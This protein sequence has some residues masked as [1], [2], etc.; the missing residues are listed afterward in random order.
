MER[1]VAATRNQDMEMHRRLEEKEIELSESRVR[2][3]QLEELQERQSTGAPASPT[4]SKW[5]AVVRKAL[6]HDTVERVHKLSAVSSALEARLQDLERLEALEEELAKTKEAAEKHKQEAAEKER[7]LAEKLQEEKSA[8]EKAKDNEQKAKE[9]A[10]AEREAAQKAEDKAQK[11]RER[12]DKEVAEAKER[13]E[14]AK[15]EATEAKERAEAQERAAQEARDSVEK[16][17]QEAAEAKE[18][19]EAKDREAREARDALEGAKQEAAEAK[20]RAE[21][22]D[23]EAQEAR[24]A[25]D[26]ARQ[27]AAGAKARGLQDAPEGANTGSASLALEQAQRE[28]ADAQRE[29]ASAQKQVAE[30]QRDA[31]E[32]QA[33]AA[34]ALSAAAQAVLSAVQEL[35]SV[36]AAEDQSAAGENLE[37]ALLETRAQAAKAEERAAAAADRA[38]RDFAFQE[39]L[40]ESQRKVS[41]SIDRVER[42]LGNFSTS[43]AGSAAGGQHR[44]L[45]EAQGA[46]LG[47]QSQVAEAQI[48]ASAAQRSAASAL[49]DAA[50]LMRDASAALSRAQKPGGAQSSGDSELESERDAANAQCARLQAEVDALQQEIDVLRRDLNGA[51][52]RS[53]DAE[54]TAAAA[55][56]AASAARDMADPQS[57]EQLEA[58]ER[59]LDEERRQ[60][61]LAEAAADEHRAR[62]NQ[63]EQKLS[64]SG[65]SAPE[66]AIQ[67][68]EQLQGELSRAR[69]RIEQLESQAREMSQSGSGGGSRATEL[70]VKLHEAR[71]AETL[72]KAREEE[73]ARKLAD[74]QSRIEQLEQQSAQWQKLA[75]APRRR[76]AVGL[77][78]SFS[79]PSGAS[80]VE[81][82]QARAEI[83]R[84]KDENEAQKRQIRTLQDKVDVYFGRSSE[85]YSELDKAWLEAARA[86]AQAGL[87]ETP[88]AGTSKSADQAALDKLQSAVG[89]ASSLLSHREQLASS[90]AQRLAAEHAAE[91]LSAAR[92]L[93]GVHSDAERVVAERQRLA[94]QLRQQSGQNRTVIVEEG[95]EVVRYMVHRGTQTDDLP[96]QPLVETT[97]VQPPAI[98]VAPLRAIP[99]E[100]SAQPLSRTA[101]YASTVST[102]VSYRLTP[103]ISYVRSAPPPPPPIP[104][105]VVQP[106]PIHMLRR[107]RP[108]RWPP[109]LVGPAILVREED[110][111]HEYYP[112][113]SA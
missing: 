66:G 10:A 81:M 82:A 11:E 38:R 60:R 74:A 61:S 86:R 72:R 16:A 29:L 45:F 90:A 32:T 98:P 26:G 35:E 8:A 18:R 65:Q 15:R 13:T 41:A 42:D 37:R 92:E 46:L 30:A 6:M 101:S 95:P 25:L 93:E 73:L 28:A 33:A 58:L 40:Q 80:S 111:T 113:L 7:D 105:S 67:R 14:A 59:Q 76:T 89:R 87:D 17:K 52:D 5:Q 96:D 107:M 91:T 69:E 83:Q 9:Q 54:A 34:S 85:I 3:A 56:R 55:I 70:E 103:Q 112:H 79:A 49:S 27:E 109:V 1:Q 39:S 110:V 48:S 36:R 43:D 104:I 53:S 97:F 78:D 20:E 63:L 106:M 68:L 47:V 64:S 23:R 99:S 44:E 102:Q 50:D 71:V 31:A 94:E 62:V 19:A 21:A 84:L 77:D 24:D 88:A 75:Q 57:R 12:A 4:G 2:L 108:R 51:L 100:T 22:K